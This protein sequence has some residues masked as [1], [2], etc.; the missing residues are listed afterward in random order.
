MGSEFSFFF[1]PLTLL[2]AL[3]GCLL[4][5]GDAIP[6]CAPFSAPIISHGTKGW[7]RTV[8]RP[9]RRILWALGHV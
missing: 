7:R 1:F 5:G 2:P 8:W 4:A 6:I 9:F 3:G